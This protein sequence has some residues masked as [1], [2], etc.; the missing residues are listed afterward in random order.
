MLYLNF[1][2]HATPLSDSI[3]QLSLSSFL[4]KRAFRQINYPISDSVN[5]SVGTIHELEDNFSIQERLSVILL[6]IY[7]KLYDYLATE[8]KALTG[9]LLF[10]SPLFAPFA[11]CNNQFDEFIKNIYLMQEDFP[12]LNIK[13]VS[14]DSINTALKQCLGE[15]D[16]H[17]LDYL[18]LGGIDSCINLTIYDH[19]QS[20]GLLYSPDTDYG[21]FPSEGGAFLVL[22]NAPNT[23]NN[24]TIYINP[25]NFNEL[26]SLPIKLHV[27]GDNGQ[28][29]NT[30]NLCKHL[31]ANKQLFVS[32]A[33][34]LITHQFGELGAASIPVG[35]LLG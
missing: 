26:C 30:N 16:S 5:L 11:F 9:K 27:S 8:K 6:Q 25:N 12:N 18:I 14:V 4:Q 34:H 23:K 32:Q 21:V 31:Q 7:A 3:E 28:L 15:L 24:K 19:L 22:S 1:S 29:S 2:A 10:I 13:L 35:L 17:S 20:S 33:V